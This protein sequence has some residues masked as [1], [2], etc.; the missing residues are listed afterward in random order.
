LFEGVFPDRLNNATIVPVY[1]KGDKRCLANCR[2]IS[3][4]TSFNKI[5]EMVDKASQ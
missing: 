2:P 1:K 3:I 5:F 4:L